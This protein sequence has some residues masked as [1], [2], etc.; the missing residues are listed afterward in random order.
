MQVDEGEK[1]LYS[2]EYLLNRL[3][4]LTG[5]RVAE[6]IICHTCT[7]GASNDIEKAT[8]MAR[9]MITTY[10]MSD[11]Y[12]MMALETKGNSYLGGSSQLACSDE[13]AADIDT[14]VREMIAAAKKKATDIITANIDK[15]HK[16]AQYLL[17]KETITGEEFMNIFNGA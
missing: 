6:E 8:Q 3:A 15:M 7:T 12:G 5:G 17:E 11:K 2:K 10:G 9:A 16:S 13:T 14:E 4:T 1:F